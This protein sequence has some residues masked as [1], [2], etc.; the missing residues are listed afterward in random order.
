MAVG[1][2]DCHRDPVGSPPH[3][4][5][6][7][8]CHTLGKYANCQA[9]VLAAYLRAR[10][11]GP[12]GV[13]HLDLADAS[14]VDRVLYARSFRLRRRVGAMADRLTRGPAVL[15]PVRVLQGTSDRALR[16]NPAMGEFKRC[17]SNVPADLLPARLV[18]L[19]GL[20]R[21]I[22]QCFRDRKQLFG[23]GDY[24]GRNW[25]GWHRHATLVMLVHFF[26]VR[27]TLRVQKTLRPDCALDLPAGERGPAPHPGQTQ[28]RFQ[29]SVEAR[30]QGQCLTCRSWTR[31]WTTL[32]TDPIHPIRATLRLP[33]PRTAPVLRPTAPVPSWAT[34]GPMPN[35]TE[36]T[37]STYSDTI[38]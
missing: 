13:V 5:S 33:W 12:G 29:G 31:S 10:S 36:G 25:Q 15:H 26:V 1:P 19:S 3:S 14:E 4:L 27:E 37:Q 22:E 11:R 20:R 6:T 38:K 21:P 9:A 35:V 16:R 23:L 17:I 24:K 30:I 32:E 8:S 34:A 28:S 2:A 18:W 7:I